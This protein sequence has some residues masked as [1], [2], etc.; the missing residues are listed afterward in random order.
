MIRINRL[1]DYATLILFHLCK[2]RGQPSSASALALSTSLPVTTVSKILKLLANAE[3]L[4]AHRGT[5]GGYELARAPSQIKI[6]EILTAIEGPISLTECTH[7][8]ASCPLESKCQLHSPWQAINKV[9]IDTLNTITL[10]DL[11]NEQHHPSSPSRWI[12]K[13]PSLGTSDERH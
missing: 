3:L 9:V 4:V 7:T 13:R 10:E 11:M 5:A 2:T 12:G 8:D 6:P 1:T